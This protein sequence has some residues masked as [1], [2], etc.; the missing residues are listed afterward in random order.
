MI[1]DLT[2][3]LVENLKLP[4]FVEEMISQIIRSG[5]GEFADISAILSNFVSINT[6]VPEYG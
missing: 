3:E 5:L 2:P 4:E 6:S 1:V